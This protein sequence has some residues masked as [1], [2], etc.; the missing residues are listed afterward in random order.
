MKYQ[1]YSQISFKKTPYY[2]NM[3]ETLRNEFD[4]L[5]KV[6][7]F[8]INNYVAEH[9]INWENL[10]DDPIYQL[11]FP[12]KDM[13]SAFDFKTLSGMI[14]DGASALEMDMVSNMVQQKIWP[15]V[16]LDED[17]IPKC[18]GDIIPGLYH[19]FPTN[20][21]LFPA[22]AVK[23]CHAVCNYCFRWIHHTRGKFLPETS[24][25]DPA[26][27]IAFL[28]DNPHIKDI[29]MTGADPLVMTT[30]QVKKFT[31]PLINVESLDVI[32]FITKSLTYWPFRFTTDKD[33]DELLDYFRYLKTQGKH[34]AIMAH[35]T[36][37]NELQ[38][39]VVKE[40]I[41]RIQETG[42]VIRCQA[43]I[44]KNINDSAQDWTE[45]W[46]TQVQLGM[47]PYHMFVEADTDP[48]GCFQIPL[49]KTVAVFQE[50]RKKATS[51]ARAVRGP[52]FMNNNMRVEILS[53]EEINNEKFF[54]LKCLQALD[55]KHEGKIRLYPFD[56]EITQIENLR[57]VF[58]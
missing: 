17:R 58:E 50:A 52:T 24:Y 43:P 16:A 13:I 35:I 33:A 36:H 20:L 47:F 11:I 41:R 54:V 9:L 5:T 15:A 56:P 3:S 2:L 53:I 31:D 51:I 57:S 18:N 38:T 8:K 45:L 39:D 27:P 23:T 19:T 4:V 22:P 26:T 29:F 14:K 48:N 28:R 12:R 40:A 6:L 32:R 21:Y 34:V 42:A 46:D 55:D 1:A 37:V 25:S 30:S 7:P 49:A 10:P 44:V